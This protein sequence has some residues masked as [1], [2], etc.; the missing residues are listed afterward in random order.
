MKTRLLFF[1]ILLF[2]G[3]IS[4]KRK[5]T[6]I[7]YFDISK[8]DS[9][10][11]FSYAS[12]KEIPSS[13]LEINIHNLKVKR[14]LAASNKF[15]FTNPIYSQDEKKIF[16]IARNIQNVNDD[17]IGMCDL[18]GNNVKYLT[19][20]HDDI[21]RIITSK[22]SNEIIYIKLNKENKPIGMDIFSLDIGSRVSK[23]ITE[24]NLF[25]FFHLHELDSVHLLTHI[26]DGENGGMFLINKQQSPATKT[27]IVPVNNPRQLPELYNNAV[28][29]KKSNTLI[30][31]APYEIFSMDLDE[32]YAKKIYRNDNGIYFFTLK[33][34]SPR[35]LFVVNGESNIYSMNLD[36]T[37]LKTI[38]V[39]I[40]SENK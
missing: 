39:N 26:V 17:K 24:S 2:T 4:N 13:I 37:D 5:F 18:D 34:N 7:G 35:I 10:I 6:E 15:E 29:H 8:S 19:N 14:V 22:Y 23:N 36:G 3:C 9:T 33:N 27:R 30:F 40:P 38:P 20:N 11:L 28:F 31:D 12:S 25:G 1:I 16:F 32:K 21:I